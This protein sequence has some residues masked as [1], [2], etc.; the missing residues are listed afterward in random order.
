MNQD[1]FGHF[2]ERTFRRHGFPLTH[3]QLEQFVTYRSE[4]HRWNSR[5]N[6]TSIRDDREVV[7]KH[8]LDSAG[9]LLHFPIEAGAAVV[10]IGTGAGFPGLPLKICLPDIKLTLIES[11][12]KKASFIQFLISQ[13]NIPSMQRDIRIV[14]QRAEAFVKHCENL[15]AYDWV[16]TRYVASLADSAV[17]CL[18]LLNRNGTW[19]AYKSHD[20][21]VEIGEAKSRFRSLGG[22]VMSVVN[23]RFSDSNRTYVEIRGGS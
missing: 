6:L 9:V 13:L 15:G 21:E 11:S 22:K 20:V 4:L 2:L 16:L 10:D 23:S 12:S 1:E 8:F 14:V 19:I 5:V 18:P 7:L 17:Y 3:D